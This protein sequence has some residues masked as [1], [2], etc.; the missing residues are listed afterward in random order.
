MKNKIGM[1]YVVLLA[2]VLLL[3]VFVFNFSTWKTVGCEPIVLAQDVNTDETGV[4]TTGFVEI[5]DDVKNIN[6]DLRVERYDRAEVTVSLTDAGD[7]YAY[8]MPA[9]TVTNDVKNCGYQNLYPFGTVNTLQVTVTVPQG[10]EA[11]IESIALNV[12]KPFEFKILR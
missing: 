3:E 8:E 2:T 12:G 5:H 10:T 6:V 9:Y 1:P 4:F 11:S 7:Y